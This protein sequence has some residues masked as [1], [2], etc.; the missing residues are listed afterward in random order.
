LKLNGDVGHRLLLEREFHLQGCI[1]GVDIFCP[2]RKG[3]VRTEL[4]PVNQS[5]MKRRH[6]NNKDPRISD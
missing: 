3:T 5:W 1:R 6:A 2:S 4:P